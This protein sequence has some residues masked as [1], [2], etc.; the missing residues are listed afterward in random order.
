MSSTASSRRIST[1]PPEASASYMAAS[2]HHGGSPSREERPADLEEPH[3][4]PSYPASVAEKDGGID[5][6]QSARDVAGAPTATKTAGPSAS[7]SPNVLPLDGTTVVAAAAAATAAAVDS[8]EP[9]GGTG[10]SAAALPAHEAEPLEKSCSL[11]APTT[12]PTRKTIECERES[13]S[14]AAAATAAAAAAAVSAV[15]VS[16]PKSRRPSQESHRS[17]TVLQATSSEN[18]NRSPRLHCHTN[19]FSKSSAIRCANYFFH[20]ED[21]ASFGV[22]TVGLYAV[23][24][25][26]T[27]ANA[28]ATG[29]AAAV[30]SP[31]L[32]RKGAG[33]AAA[34]SR[35][36][37]DAHSGLH[38]GRFHHGQ[39]MPAASRRYQP[40]AGDV[41]ST[42][43]VLS[44]LAPRTGAS[45]W[46]RREADYQQWKGRYLAS[47]SYGRFSLRAGLRKAPNA[48]SQTT[49]NNNDDN[50]D[51]NG[52]GFAMTVPDDGGS[53]LDLPVLWS[54]EGRMRLE[55]RRLRALEAERAAKTAALTQSQKTYDARVLRLRSRKLKGE[56]VDLPD[57]Y[58]RETY[59]DPSAPKGYTIPF[60]SRPAAHGKADE[61]SDDDAIDAR[62]VVKDHARARQLHRLE[63]QQRH[64]TEEARRQDAAGKQ[65]QQIG[66]QLEERRALDT[67]FR[68]AWM[69]GRPRISRSRETQRHGDEEAAKRS[70]AQWNHTQRDHERELYARYAMADSA[71][72]TARQRE[73]RER[74][75]TRPHCHTGQAS[76]QGTTAGDTER[77]KRGLRSSSRLE[78]GAAGSRATSPLPP[79][80]PPPSASS[81]VAQAA[82]APSSLPATASKNDRANDMSEVRPV[83]P[84]QLVGPTSTNFF[85][86]VKLWTREFPS[87]NTVPMNAAEASHRHAWKAELDEAQLQ[88]NRATTQRQRELYQR[89]LL[90]AREKTQE[91]NWTL[92]EQ[93]RQE[94]K[95][96][97]SR[98]ADQ[99]QADLLAATAMRVVVQDEAQRAQLE[100]QVHMGERHDEAQRQRAQ[101][102]QREKV[103][104]SLEAEE[105]QQLRLAVSA[106]GTRA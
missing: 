69:E 44:L 82:S 64:L 97:A 3:T 18:V 46:A 30:A 50:S 58:L 83:T 71:E 85:N 40:F 76:P 31:M 16:Q 12:A 101:S 105:L 1:L 67:E 98:R 66:K 45:L 2:P 4:L 37:D 84:S 78:G 92:A 6:K 57:A 47:S 56:A 52:T 55:Q 42:S 26:T 88:F 95:V 38:N 19:N 106:H 81:A 104:R 9:E 87:P 35:G 70:A 90:E 103:L 5:H 48:N 94:R 21:L 73:L 36:D 29:A 41:F 28:A 53:H 17:S 49:N 51:N 23:K 86:E 91:A 61:N 39:D 24:T 79:S 100:R 11:P 99:A 77:D 22:G 65:R 72:T 75:L 10:N 96:F 60:A 68:V 8:A 59:P 102:K 54:S 20:N 34:V 15:A 63:L 13:L 14:A 62:R 89:H 93:E 33:T 7:T 43:D 27:T 25:A 80:L 32:S 74:V